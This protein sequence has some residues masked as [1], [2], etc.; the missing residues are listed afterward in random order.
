MPA[1]GRRL[2]LVPSPDPSGGA[3]DLG[4]R[5]SGSAEAPAPPRSRPLAGTYLVV[6]GVGGGEVRLVRTVDLVH[7]IQTAH[8][9]PQRSRFRGLPSTRGRRGAGMLHGR[10]WDPSSG[11]IGEGAGAVRSAARAPA[12]TLRSRPGNSSPDRARSGTEAP[13]LR[14]VGI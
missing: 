11:V 3:L 14:L 7:N 5:T 13:G 4:V 1:S 12:R 2:P 10:P 9:S 8:G 6:G